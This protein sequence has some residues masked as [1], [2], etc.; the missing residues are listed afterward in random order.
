MKYAI[1]IDGTLPENRTD[2][3]TSYKI[4]FYDQKTRDMVYS[5]RMMLKG[6]KIFINEDLTIKKSKLAYETRQYAK[7][8]VGSST[9]TQ[10]GKVFLKLTPSSK[11]RTILSVAD[12]KK[13]DTDQTEITSEL[14]TPPS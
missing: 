11:P 4:N 12:F 10:D 3:T 1:P 14:D 5:N 6:T 9:W 7:T 8:K 13:T 2:N